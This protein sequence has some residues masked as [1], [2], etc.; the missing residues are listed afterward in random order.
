MGAGAYPSCHRARGRVH[1]GQAGS[2]S[3]GYHGEIMEATSTAHIH[4]HG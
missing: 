2:M 1:R 4:A 3:H